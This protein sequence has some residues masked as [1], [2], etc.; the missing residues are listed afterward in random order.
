LH[1]AA[2]ARLHHEV[3]S[4]MGLVDQDGGLGELQRHGLYVQQVV[5]L[6]CSHKSAGRIDLRDMKI[7]G[8]LSSSR[9]LDALERA[10]S[11]PL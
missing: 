7:V 8:S 5:V 11:S 3:R 9:R 2:G 4:R 6:L 1:A 10:V